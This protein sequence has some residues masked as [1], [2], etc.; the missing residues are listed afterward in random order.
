MSTC[1][2]NPLFGGMF[3]IGGGF[4]GGKKTKEIFFDTWNQNFE[5]IME[6]YFNVSKFSNIYDNYK[7]WIVFSLELP[8]KDPDGEID[9]QIPKLIQGNSWP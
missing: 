4:T 3:L 2:D 7:I 5:E 9:A 8:E 6:H 1:Y